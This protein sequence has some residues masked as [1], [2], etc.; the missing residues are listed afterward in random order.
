MKSADAKRLGFIDLR[1]SS[2]E[3]ETFI[4]HAQINLNII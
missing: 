4:H 2:E 3:E 1:F